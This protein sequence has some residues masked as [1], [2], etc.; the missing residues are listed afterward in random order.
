MWLTSRNKKITVFAVY[1]LLAITSLDM[2]RFMLKFTPFVSRELIF[3]QTRTLEFLKTNL[4]INRFMSMDR[5]IM[6][7]NVS[8]YYQL[9]T[10]EGYDPLYLKNYGELMA[11]MTRN[12]PDIKPAT[13]NRILTPQ[14]PD[15]W[16]TNLLGV[17]YILALDELTNPKLNLVFAEGNTKVY[18]NLEVLPRV[19]LVEEVE[20]VTNKEEMIR[21]MFLDQDKLNKKA[22]TMSSLS[23][24]PTPLAAREIVALTDYSPQQIVIHAE[25]LQERLLVLTDVYYPGWKATIDGQ[26]VPIHEVDLAFRG[27]VIPKGSHDLI[28]VF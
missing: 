7:P 8:T 13:F 25:T 19:F 28:L 17:K 22:F 4:G 23:L 9:Q 21:R 27:V 12:R 3:P 26:P 15:S 18:E 11:A 10:I 16:L 14:T 5:R 2:A 1:L 20:I 24:V 6:P